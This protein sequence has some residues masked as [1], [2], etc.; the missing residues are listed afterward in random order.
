MFPELASSLAS[1]AFNGMAVE[2]NWRPKALC[3]PGSGVDRDV[4]FPAMGH[5]A[6]DQEYAKGLCRQ[7]PVVASCLAYALSM[8]FN[9]PG[10]WGG[11]TAKQRGD[12]RARTRA[13]QV[14]QECGGQIRDGS[15]EAVYCA[16]HRNRPL[17]RR[18]SLPGVIYA[19]PGR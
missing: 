3:R 17:A 5:T 7:C 15:T 8:P 1:L 6:K 10:I 13:H 11:T 16:E 14:C 2:R 12:L 18:G 19:R 9:P 4:F